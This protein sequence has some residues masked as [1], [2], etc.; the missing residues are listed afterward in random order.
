MD[1][2]QQP[3]LSAASP[4]T[5]PVVCITAVR[6]AAY[7]FHAD[8]FRFLFQLRKVCPTSVN[9]S[10]FL[11]RSGGNLGEDSDADQITRNSKLLYSVAPAILINE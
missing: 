2:T 4:T 11:H 10:Y 3:L 7:H 1:A 5:A 6:G 8:Q 9:Q